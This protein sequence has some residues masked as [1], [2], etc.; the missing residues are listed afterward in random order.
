MVPERSLLMIA[1]S[2]DATIEANNKLASLSLVDEMR[3]FTKIWRLTRKKTGALSP[4]SV[5]LAHATDK[6]P[7]QV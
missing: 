3:S 6:M 4:A 7:L 2:E 5:T 1:S